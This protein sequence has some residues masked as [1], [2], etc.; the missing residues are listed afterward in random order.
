MKLLLL[1]ILLQRRAR[2]EGF[3]LPMVIALGLVMLLLGTINIVKSNEENITAISQ[4]SSS[5]ALAVAEAGVTKYRELLNQNRILTVYNH[6]QWA[7]NTTVSGQTCDS[8][9]TTPRGWKDG[10]TTA[11][12]N[13]TGKWWEVKENIDGNPGVDRIGEYRLVS[14]EYDNDGIINDNNDNGIFDVFSDADPADDPLTLA[15]GVAANSIV[16]E[17]DTNDDGKSDAVGILTVQGRSPDG[18]EA[19]IRV[20]IPL[21]INDLNNFAPILWVKSGAISTP[22]NLTVT[23][24]S[25]N[26]GNIVLKSSGTGCSTPAAIAGKSNVISDP[27]NLPAII[28][29]PTGIQLSQQNFSIDTNNPLE[30]LFPRPPAI[31]SDEKDS[32]GRFLYRVST[33]K[34]ENNNL[35]TDGTAKATLYA[36]GNITINGSV[37]NTITVGNTN[38]ATRNAGDIYANFNNG[39]TTNTSVSSHNLE[40]YGSST[41]TQININPNGGTVNVEAFIHAPNATLNI[42]GGGTVNI[43]GAVWVNNFNNS[44][45]ATVNI[46]SDKTSTTTVAEPAYKFYTT[47]ATMTPRPLTSTPTNWVREEVQ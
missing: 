5:D 32:Q 46:R 26:K 24:T 38:A 35:E 10:G 1:K 37:G 2:D 42:T 27:R 13:D 9:A 25:N 33:I 30:R 39:S 34:V 45:G 3:T 19:Q 6:D 31:P 20:E 21:R 28:T 14:Y 29:D 4:N 15:S 36:T 11:A 41:T 44:G 22:G 12:P 7:S 17:N 18:S 40:I 23:N 47:S 43:N 16:D 8:M